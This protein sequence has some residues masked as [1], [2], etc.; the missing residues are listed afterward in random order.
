[1]SPSDSNRITALTV[2]EWIG[3]ALQNCVASLQ[4]TIMVL[5]KYCE[6]KGFI[7]ELEQFIPTR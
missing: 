2:L 5:D 7:L 1:M 6:R 4:Y 3:E